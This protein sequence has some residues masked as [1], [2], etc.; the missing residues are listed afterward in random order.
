[1]DAGTLQDPQFAAAWILV[2]L[3]TTLLPLL[4]MT[5][6]APKVRYTWLLWSVVLVVV[7]LQMTYWIG[8]QRYSTRYYYE[9]L[10]AAALLSALPLGWLAHYGSRRWLYAGLCMVLAGSFIAYSLPRVQSLYRYN[11]I[12]REVIAGVEARRE[13]D[14]PVLV[15]VTGSD[16]GDARVR[17]RALGALMAVTS[18]FLDSEIVVAWDYQSAGIRALIEQRF[19][20]RQIIEM[21]G[22]GDTATFLAP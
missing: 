5:Q 22:I 9:A 18:P 17:W 3:A 16:E 8:S 10:A 14:R 21:Q 15:I 1:L 7:L 13:G 6:A 20:E 19:P 2:A 12:G 4:L 11:Q